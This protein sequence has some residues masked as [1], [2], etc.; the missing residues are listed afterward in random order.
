MAAHT[1]V[2]LQDAGFEESK[3]DEI[4]NVD[5]HRST[6]SWQPISS[7]DASFVPSLEG[8]RGIAIALTLFGHTIEEPYILREASG[9]MGV[10]IF[11][12]LSG[13]L[14][15]GVLIRLENKHITAESSEKNRVSY[16]HLGHFYA[17]RMVRLAPALLFMV[18]IMNVLYRFF[19]TDM[20]D[21]ASYIQGYS[22]LAVFYVQNIPDLWPKSLDPGP[23]GQTWSLACEEQYY[24]IWSL[25]LPF[26]IRM[27][28][29]LRCIVAFGL[30]AI[31]YFIRVHTSLVGIVYGVNWKFSL[32]S[33]VWKM[34]LGSALRFVP[35]PGWLYRQS[36]AYIG[37]LGI[38]LTLCA[39][40]G[41]QPFEYKANRYGS[42]W[43][44]RAAAS[45]TWTDPLSAI[46]A[47]LVIIG[48]HG[49]HGGIWLLEGRALRFAGK[50]SYSWYLWQTSLLVFTHWVRGAQSARD[51]G[52]AFLLA[53]VSTFLIEKPI[54]QWYKSV[55]ERRQNARH[56]P[57]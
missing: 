44:D 38:V 15:T 37:V 4:V 3:T 17:D 34:V 36:T 51:T 9:S 25:L 48:V 49:E 57:V 52:T 35:I 42:G 31:S 27:K 11:F 5:H 14:I 56:Q 1:I 32:A 13:F 41:P 40:V 45:Q 28:V 24:I 16:R 54:G 2:S 26:I 18:L 6:S 29:R 50:V 21:V 12:V 23:F 47:V 19:R 39:M 33:N 10:T 55:K 20:E 53:L 8:L 46:S 30:I 22:L 43:T 7:G